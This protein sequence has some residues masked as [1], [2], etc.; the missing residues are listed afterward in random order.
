VLRRSRS[1]PLDPSTGDVSLKA[2]GE[3]EMLSLPTGW[4][5]SELETRLKAFRSCL[6]AQSP[7]R[8]GCQG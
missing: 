7:S 4:T 6:W 3:G 1:A 2:I 5:G 8:H